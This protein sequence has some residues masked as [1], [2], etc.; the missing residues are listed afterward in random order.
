MF[1]NPWALLLLLLAAPIAWLYRRRAVAP[2]VSTATVA[3]WRQVLA[4]E[5]ARSWWL[6]RRRAVSLAV[7]LLI[8][9]LA[10][11]ALAQ[12]RLSPP[13][14]IILILDNSGSMNTADVSP[15]RF[16]LA[17]RHA[18]RLID[19]LPSAD[20][21]A[22]LTGGALP[23]V[24]CPPS[25]NRRQLRDSL[26]TIDAGT[27]PTRVADAVTLARWMLG[28]EQAGRIVV[29]SDA[30]FA[31]ASSVAKADDV[32]L[33]T[34]GGP[35]SNVAVRRVAIRRDPVEPE[36]AR[37]LVEVASHPVVTPSEIPL[38]I[39]LDGVVLEET[40]AEGDTGRHSV[41]VFAVPTAEPGLL[42]V[43]AK[44]DDA[45]P[46]D[47]RRGARVPPADMLHVTSVGPLSRFIETALAA[48]PRVRLTKSAE[49][50][51]SSDD[52]TIFVL[53][54]EVPPKLPAGPILVVAPHSGCDLWEIDGMIP[55]TVIGRQDLSSSIG[56][57]LDL[58]GITLSEVG[59]LKL[60]AIEPH[61]MHVVAAT[62]EAEPLLLALD[63]QQGR[64][65][66][67][68]GNPDTS[69]LS[70][71]AE[72]L[73]LIAQAIDWIDERVDHDETEHAAQDERVFAASESDL[74]VPAGVGTPA[75]QWEL[76]GPRP[77]L[78]QFFGAM[79][80]ALLTVEWR[81]YQRRWIS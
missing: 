17:R 38:E 43:L 57:G 61:A 29:L 1:A 39:R 34:V 51:S 8:L 10:V 62:A 12:P 28:G 68:L 3:I 33:Y 24:V 56:A 72:F 35:A 11:L 22:V 6:P 26:E 49:I 30:C 74:R 63:R 69:E 60:Q 53:Q 70:H 59:R 20:R 76:R 77:A 50:P 21:L 5:R 14:T 58:E 32:D 37:A 13:R 79:V 55:Y 23:Q 48:N 78:W 9:A 73:L 44:R 80:I 40:L 65:V 2:C 81:L 75:D 46:A 45:L 67:L 15:S 54:G 31:D 66:V 19:S 4:E 52:D 16:E 18:R 27:G 71:Q 64:V 36:L 42:S 7:Q 47:N 41:R 25:L